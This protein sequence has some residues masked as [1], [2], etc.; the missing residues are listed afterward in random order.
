MAGNNLLDKG[1]AGPWHADDQYRRS[2]GAAE[3][4]RT[5]AHAGTEPLDQTVDF[6]IERGGIERSGVR[7]KYIGR[8]KVLHRPPVFAKVVSGF[9]QGEVNT[10][11]R[12][13]FQPRR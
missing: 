6:S 5:L 4:R 11:A 12:L 8:V 10:H 1:C 9:A 13:E 7:A 3:F 2:V